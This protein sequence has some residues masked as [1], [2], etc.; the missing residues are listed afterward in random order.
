MTQPFVCECCGQEKPEQVSPIEHLWAK[1]E[2]FG[3]TV[4]MVD[5]T[6]SEVSA[7]LLVGYNSPDA[8]RRRIELG[9]D[10][11]PYKTDPNGR[12]RYSLQAIADYLATK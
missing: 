3:I 1:C 9:K 10:R 6:V 2:E 11:L 4:R 12:R 7:N 8:L 5:N